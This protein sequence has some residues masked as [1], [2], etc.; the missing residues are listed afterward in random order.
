M[1]MSYRVFG[2]YQDDQIVGILKVK[3]SSKK[4][5]LNNSE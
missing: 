4:Y 2:N 1:K 5:W 3:T